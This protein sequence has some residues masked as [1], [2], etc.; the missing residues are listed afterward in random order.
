M[1]AERQMW[2][3]NTTQPT[4]PLQCGADPIQWPT[5]PAGTQ[6]TGGGPGAGGKAAWRRQHLSW[7]S[8]LSSIVSPQNSYP[9]GPVNVTSFG[10]CLCRHDQV[11]TRSHW[12]RVGPDPTTDILTGRGKR[13]RRY[14]GR[15]AETGAVRLQAEEQLGTLATTGSGRKQ[16]E[17]PQRY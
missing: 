2:G 13:P 6:R 9:P 4:C 11:K 10:K 5:C 15:K 17:P 8:A 12:I 16:Q 1:G 3:E 7:A 14:T